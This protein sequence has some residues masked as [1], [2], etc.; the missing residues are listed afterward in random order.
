MA[1]KK[2]KKIQTQYTCIWKNS[3]T[4]DNKEENRKI[5]VLELT[6]LIN[7]VNGR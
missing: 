1:D 4:N 3:R 6:K 5:T 2:K 7:Q